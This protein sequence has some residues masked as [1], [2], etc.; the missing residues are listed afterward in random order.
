MTND[1]ET[2]CDAQQQEDVLSREVI[3]KHGGKSCFRV[4]RNRTRHTIMRCL[5][6]PWN[7][8][9][10]HSKEVIRECGDLPCVEVA[11]H[12]FWAWPKNIDCQGH[13]VSEEVDKKYR[14]PEQ[15]LVSAVPYG[16]TSGNGQ[17]ST[18]YQRTYRAS[19][20]SVMFLRPHSIKQTA[21]ISEYWKRMTTHI[22]RWRGS[23]VLRAIWGT[24]DNQDQKVLKQSKDHNPV[25][26]S[27]ELQAICLQLQTKLCKKPIESPANESVAPQPPDSHAPWS[28]F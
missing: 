28:K 1:D 8:Q 16:S 6:M 21:S 10:A 22:L 14:A 4:A 19:K 15:S 25:C 12:V 24:F 7:R 18:A 17:N 5:E 26:P 27:S 9:D 2:S 23:P 13:G 20:K 11:Y 3:R